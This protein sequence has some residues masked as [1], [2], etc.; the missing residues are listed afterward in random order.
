VST[1]VDSGGGDELTRARSLIIV[2]ASSS[3]GWIP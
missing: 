1:A 3:S 2:V